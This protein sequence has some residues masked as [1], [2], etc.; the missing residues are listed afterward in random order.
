MSSPEKQLLSI[1]KLGN[2]WE[3]WGELITPHLEDCSPANKGL[4]GHVKGFRLYLYETG[5]T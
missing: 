1:P 4:E 2:F 5:N 3:N